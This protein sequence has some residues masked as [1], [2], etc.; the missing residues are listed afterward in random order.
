MK[1]YFQEI[2][3]CRYFWMSLVKMD[4]RTRYRRSILGMG[5]SLLHPIAMT[6]I[7]TM[8]F[9]ILAP[10][11]NLREYAP[12]LITGL[13]TWNFIVYA[14]LSG[15]QT[16]FV[17]ES[18]IRQYPAPLAIYPLRTTLGGIIHFLVALI[19][20]LGLAW[21][22]KGFGNLPVLV[23]LL[24]AVL[25]LFIFGWSLAVLTGF[26]NVH[27][28]D[29]QHL[30]EVGFQIL[31]YASPIMYDMSLLESKHMAWLARCNPIVP[32][33]ELVRRPILKA[34]FPSLL[35]Y[36]SAMLIVVVVAG[37]AGFTLKRLQRK[38]IFHM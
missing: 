9:Y 10:S 17:G 15:C 33:L 28:Q 18:Y 8:V 27:F 37:A 32:L 16:F 7:L 11:P 30:C 26:S 1:N 12:Y 22:C 31:F 20:V 6:C 19:V 4:L 5:W 25:L 21:Y 13:V 35:D 38:L 3:R 34:E 14:A 29:T 36:G 23:S 2:W 24:P